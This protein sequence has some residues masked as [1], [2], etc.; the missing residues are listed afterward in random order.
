MAM[1][2]NL[3][4]LNPGTFF[5]FDEEEPEDGITLRVLNQEV[6]EKI[7][8]VCRV[9]KSQIGGN[10][11]SRFTY[12]DFKPGGEEKQFEMTWD[13]CIMEWKGVVDN[14]GKPIPCT[15]EN[16]VKLM[17]GSQQFASFVT[18]CAAK[19]NEALGV[20]EETLEGN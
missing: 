10:P 12:L 16:K 9:R 13:Y 7:D 15:T 20:Q 3:D 14:D 1:K 18:K 6:L 4:D 11:P 19:L 2:F 17:K 5:P 8:K